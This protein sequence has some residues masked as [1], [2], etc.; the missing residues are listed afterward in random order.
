MGQKLKIAVFITVDTIENIA[1]VCVGDK[2]GSAAGLRI[3]C[4]KKWQETGEASPI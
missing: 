3:L 2:K 4:H 1:A